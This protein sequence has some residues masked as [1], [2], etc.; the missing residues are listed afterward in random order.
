MDPS[1]S[2]YH[3]SWPYYDEPMEWGPILV[4]VFDFQQLQAAE[5]CGTSTRLLAVQVPWRGLGQVSHV[6]SRWTHTAYRLQ[7]RFTHV[8]IR[9]H[10][11]V[12]CP[13]TTRI[14][15]ASPLCWPKTV[16]LRL[17]EPLLRLALQGRPGNGAHLEIWQSFGATNVA[18]WWD[19]CQKLVE[20]DRTVSLDPS[21]SD[22]L[23]VDM[24]G[25][26]NSTRA[27]DN[28]RG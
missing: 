4:F 17:P 11:S 18:N 26:L 27:T 22:F 23:R 3:H 13:G 15:V 7:M 10:L 2:N 6:H 25:R 1:P 8:H 5:V 16:P 21:D 9:D 24:E 19:N 14:C 12:N 28:G 20:I